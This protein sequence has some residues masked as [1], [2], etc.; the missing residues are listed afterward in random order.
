MTSNKS[1]ST[2]PTCLLEEGMTIN[3]KWEILNFIAKGGKGEVY[4]A[5]QLNLDRQVA[6]KIMSREFIKSLEDDEEE[7]TS[8][9]MRFRR[10]VHLMARMQHPNILQVYDFDK[11]EIDGMELDYIVMEY[12]PGQTLRQK[13]PEN[14]FGHDEI[15]V[16]KWLK[17]YFFP[18]LD[19]MKTVHDN[20]IV[21]RDMKPEN[22]LIFD[23]PPKIM[24]FGI[25][26]GYHMDNVTRDHHMLGTI[27]YMPEEQFMDLA[28]TDA[29]VDVYALGKILYE[30]IEGKIKKEKNK[31]FSSVSLNEP[32]TLFFKALHRIIHQAT[33]QDRNKRIP[34]VKILHDSL[35]E[36]VMDFDDNTTFK[37]NETIHGH[38]YW[39]YL[40]VAGIVVIFI[41]A[42][43]V[44]IHYFPG[45]TLIGNNHLEKH[46]GIKIPEVTPFVITEFKFKKPRPTSLPVAD[47]KSRL[48]DK[49][50]ASDNMTMILLKGGRASIHFDDTTLPGGKQ[51]EKIVSVKTFYM[52]RTK[53]TN[54]LYVRFLNE[55][56]GIKVKNKTVLRNGRLLLLLGEV[57]EG[58]EPIMFKDNKFIINPDDVSKPVVRVTPVGALAYANF[59]GKSLPSM[60]QW[61]YAV[62]AGGS[63]I[64]KENSPADSAIQPVDQ[65]TA[66]EAG[67][68]GLEQNVNE[69]T[70]SIAGD[71]NPEFHIHGGVG[72]PSHRKL[73][74]E[75]QPWEAFSSVGFRTVLNLNEK[76]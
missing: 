6:L 36:L 16:K 21:H 24:D 20:G 18:I 23:G 25:A 38:K 1:E 12:I 31:P 32:E 45:K 41:F 67:F 8:E 30:V 59:Y 52:D 15:K 50:F 54:Y 76:K 70:M 14:G 73:Y 75:R 34:S 57:R 10:E 64:L 35:K 48:P 71:G 51:K 58:Y 46:P 7:I 60:G 19:G 44:K 55:V 56:D 28:L 27:N 9:I 74:L 65:T 17:K 63:K 33:E 66:T 40:L 39:R 62:Q 26:G 49:L 4:L 43:A 5:K 2:D 29:R 13:M 47:K 3:D 42:G 37:K 61:W 11:M 69:W 72:E 22:V 68:F 53:I